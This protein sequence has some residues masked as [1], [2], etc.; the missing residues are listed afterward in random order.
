[1]KILKEKTMKKNFYYKFLKIYLS[2][3]FLVFTLPLDL[4][5]Q[6]NQQTT[7]GLEFTMIINNSSVYHTQTYSSYDKIVVCS[8]FSKITHF[9]ITPYFLFN[10]NN[11]ILKVLLN[12]WETDDY[13]LLP[14]LASPEYLT[15]STDLIYSSNSFDIGIHQVLFFSQTPGQTSSGVN[16]T[17]STFELEDF[18]LVIKDI[19]SFINITLGY[20]GQYFANPNFRSFGPN[21][22][23]NSKIIDP[24]SYNLYPLFLSIENPYTGRFI[25]WVYSG[26]NATNYID[27][28]LTFKITYFKFDFD[29]AIP[30]SQNANNSSIPVEDYFANGLARFHINY[31]NNTIGSFN[32][33]FVPYI[34]K[35][36][37]YSTGV[38]IKTYYKEYGKDI[39]SYFFAFDYSPNLSFLKDWQIVFS[40]DGWFDKEQDKR[41]STRTG[42]GTVTNPYIYAFVPANTFSIGFDGRYKLD[43]LIKGFSVDAL[44]I[45]FINSN[46]KYETTNAD[47]TT[48]ADYVNNLTSNTNNLVMSSYNERN[49]ILYN[50]YGIPNIYRLKLF[51]GFNYQFSSFITGL[52]FEY[53]NLFGDVSNYFDFNNSLTEFPDRTNPKTPYGYF[54]RINIIL[55][56]YY[57]ID[58]NL[59][60]GIQFNLFF[61]PGLPSATELGYTNFTQPNGTVVSA[62]DQYKLDRNNLPLYQINFVFQ[63]LF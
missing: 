53:I 6:N 51:L 32:F 14:P 18:Y 60:F 48:W 59:L 40:I 44:F 10:F 35:D 41:N 1:M 27:I 17:N 38:I 62:E 22:Y 20:S 36:R 26:P 34:N 5:A 11:I 23:K 43:S 19:L 8:I 47:G 54:D 33:Y 46:N 61:Y 49:Y 58:K 7:V 42:S 56:G 16:F 31:S 28:L 30:Y 37:Y 4:F 29:F 55:K 9:H 45:Y 57:T 2:L 50:Y 3:I 15:I 25:G 13:Q 52:G 24:L 12:Y 39:S 21:S 63:I